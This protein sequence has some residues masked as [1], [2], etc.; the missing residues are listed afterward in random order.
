MALQRPLSHSHCA[1]PWATPPCSPLYL[2]SFQLFAEK[3]PKQQKIFMLWALRRRDLVITVPA[4]MGLFGIYVQVMT[5]HAI[6]AQ[7]TSPSMG[8]K[9][10][11]RTP[12]RSIQVPASCPWKML[13]PTQTVPSFSSARPRLS[14]WRASMWVL[15]GEGRHG[16]CNS[17]GA[18]WVQQWQ[19]QQEDHLCWLWT[20]LI[21]LMCVTLISRPFFCSFWEQPVTSSVLNVP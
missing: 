1:Q 2:V 16:Y 3:V 19:D 15:P 21:N 6:M 9:L 11:I 14:G 8:R 5:S 12:S 20:T 10:R 7:T 13:D 17:H 18:L 4:F